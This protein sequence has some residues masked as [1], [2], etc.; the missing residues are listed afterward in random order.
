VFLSQGELSTIFGMFLRKSCAS[1][2]KCVWGFVSP[3]QHD[4]A[5][6]EAQRIWRKFDWTFLRRDHDS[7]VG[8]F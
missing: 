2:H 7:F 8:T 5:K 1:C 3:P 4:R 6:H